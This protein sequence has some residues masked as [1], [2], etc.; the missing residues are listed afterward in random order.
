LSAR[1]SLFSEILHEGTTAVPIKVGTEGDV[2]AAEKKYRK[3]WMAIPAFLVL[4]VFLTCSFAA[5]E[6]TH[7][8]K[9][10]FYVA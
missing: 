6:Q 5:P 2:M 10:V 4:A 7:D 3:G 9:A 1:L 8:A